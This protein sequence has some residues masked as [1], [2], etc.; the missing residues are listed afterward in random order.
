MKKVN[1]QD[2][3][4]A[5]YVM[6]GNYLKS[7]DETTTFDE[8]TPITTKHEIILESEMQSPEDEVIKK[9]IYQK[10]SLEA[11]QVISICLNCPA[12]I[13]E[14]ITPRNSKKIKKDKLIK[15]LQHRWNRR[16][17]RK[18]LNEITALMKHF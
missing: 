7:V 12:E 3:V 2:Y 14:L 17:V 11:K 9:D 18:V 5:Y 1:P 6:R 4:Q 13:L 16:L 8:F 15:Y 10:M